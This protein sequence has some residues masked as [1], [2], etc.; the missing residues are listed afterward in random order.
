MGG[1]QLKYGILERQNGSCM[2]K[3][4]QNS[5]FQITH[6]EHITTGIRITETLVC[7]SPQGIICISIKDSGGILTQSRRVG[8]GRM[9]DLFF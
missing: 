9:F 1:K 2:T 7:R 6:T 5:Q 8:G 4:R 3:L